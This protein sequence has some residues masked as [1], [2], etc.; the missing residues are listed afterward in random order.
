MP[1]SACYAAACPLLRGRACIALV[2]TLLVLLLCKCVVAPSTPTAAPETRAHAHSGR[3]PSGHH[4][5]GRLPNH[6]MQPEHAAAAAVAKMSSMVTQVLQHGSIGSLFNSPFSIFPRP[7]LGPAPEVT[8]THPT[9]HESQ[10][11]VKWPVCIFNRA[12]LLGTFCVDATTQ[13]MERDPANLL[14]RLS[15]NVE[16]QKPSTA[17]VF[18]LNDN[19][20]AFQRAFPF[21]GAGNR[22][23]GCEAVMEAATATIFAS[24]DT[25]R[26]TGTRALRGTQPTKWYAVAVDCSHPEPTCPNITEAVITTFHP[27]SDAEPESCRFSEQGALGS[28]LQMRDLLSEVASMPWPNPLDVIGVGPFGVAMLYTACVAM[29]A[30]AVLF[31]MLSRVEHDELKKQVHL[32][33]AFAVTT[34]G[35]CYLAMA[36]GNGLVI[37]RKTGLSPS[38]PFCAVYT[39]THTHTNTHKQTHTHK[40]TRTHTHVYTYTCVCVCVCLREKERWCVCWRVCAC[41]CIYTC[42]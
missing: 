10:R 31:A 22:S 3:L 37:L 38:L 26:I 27:D 15:F 13:Q 20:G 1:S 9:L 36:T 16:P 25:G 12:A 39:H 21:A 14:P 35:L 40:H 17:T 6:A 19:D 33:S 34:M 18:L 2:P 28:L 24:A 11:T 32:R 5:H 4:G 8:V 29:G 42:I 30:C 7:G 41:V 23:A